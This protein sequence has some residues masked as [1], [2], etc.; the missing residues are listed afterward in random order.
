MN[1]DIS[2]LAKFDNDKLELSAE[3]LRQTLNIESGKL[4]WTELQIHFARGNV[5]VIDGSLDLIKVSEK[6]VKDDKIAIET[7]MNKNKIWR[8]TDKDA[9]QWQE[10]NPIFW[11]VVV[12]PWVLVQVIVNTD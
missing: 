7:W 12:P 11:A 10:T 9:I 1:S 3:E 6:F 8:S 4:E 5:V 2:E